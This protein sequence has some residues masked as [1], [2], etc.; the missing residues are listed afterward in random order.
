MATQEPTLADVLRES[1]RAGIAKIHTSFPATVVAY[2][3]T[4]Q[5]ADIQ[6]ALHSR[7]D[8]VLLDIE[9]PD[10]APPPQLSG[11]PVVWPSG[12]GAGPAWSLHGP[13]TPGDPVTVVVAERSTDEWCTLGAPTNIPLDAR[14]FDLSDAVCYP[15]GRSTNPGGS[16]L[17]AP[18]AVTATDPAAVVLAGALVKFGAGPTAIHPLIQSTVFLGLLDTFLIDLAASV[19]AADI[20]AAAVAFQT[21]L[22]LTPHT[23]IKVFT[24]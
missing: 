10:A 23:S 14:R 8:D 16:P 1:V 2:D 18:I 6:P 13:L 9:R 22:S 4:T 7:I 5:T 24:E 17:T 15:G 20:A 19:T 21:A 11:V 12:G 3:P